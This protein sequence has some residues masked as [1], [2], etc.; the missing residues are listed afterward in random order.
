[1]TS[2]QALHSQTEQ[3]TQMAGGGPPDWLKQMAQAFSNP[4]MA[5]HL[6]KTFTEKNHQTEETYFKI[7]VENEKVVENMLSSLGQ[8]FK[9]MDLGK[10]ENDKH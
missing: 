8:L 2:S 4:Q 5:S 6:A 9:A 1:M 7:P 10:A 3:Q